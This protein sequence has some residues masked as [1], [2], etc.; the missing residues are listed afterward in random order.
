MQDTFSN[1][2]FYEAN[3]G[4][5]GYRLPENISKW[6]SAAL[7]RDAILIR[8]QDDRLTPLDPER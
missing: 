5:K 1:L 3:R 6:L 7:K 8:A 4:Y 2:E